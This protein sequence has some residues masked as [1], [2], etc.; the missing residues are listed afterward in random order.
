MD[1]DPDDV[2]PNEPDNDAPNG[3]PWTLEDTFPS[4]WV[5][6]WPHQEAPTRE[7][8]GSAFAAWLGRDIDAQSPENEE[9]SVL[10]VMAFALDGT[11]FPSG[12]A[13]SL[14]SI[15]LRSKNVWNF[16]PN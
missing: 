11:R 6:F 2:E 14:M 7:E 9:D 5:V 10:W 1:V 4:S 3:S 13:Q 15:I 8:I 12:K 16:E